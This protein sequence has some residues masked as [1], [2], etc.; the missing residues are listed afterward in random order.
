MVCSPIQVR[1]PIK[2]NLCEGSNDI[3]RLSVMAGLIINDY[4][5]DDAENGPLNCTIA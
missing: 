3:S 5:D 2:Q 1:E 4:D